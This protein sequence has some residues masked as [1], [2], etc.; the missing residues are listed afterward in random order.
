MGTGMFVLLSSVLTFG[1]P[2]V[3]AFR[4]LLVLRRGGG[5]GGSWERD[6]PRDTPPA[7]LP[8]GG[9]P[10]PDCLVPKRLPRA[11]ARSRVLE[12]A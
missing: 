11:T 9:K 8:A 3:L 6:R 12:D 5:R 2:L 7:P 1:V 10:L 4:E